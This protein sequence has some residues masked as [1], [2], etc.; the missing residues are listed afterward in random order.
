MGHGVHMWRMPDH[1]LC[2]R[3]PPWAET[4]PPFPGPPTCPSAPRGDACRDSRPLCLP[5]LSSFPCRAAS[6]EVP[7]CSPSL[8]TLFFLQQRSGLPRCP[9]PYRQ[10]LFSLVSAFSQTSRP[11]LCRHLGNNEWTQSLQRVTWSAT[12]DALLH[13]GGHSAAR[14]TA[15]GSVR[16]WQPGSSGWG[17]RQGRAVRGVCLCVK[18][19][20]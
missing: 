13:P 16:P 15:P 10:G 18:C 7:P 4:Q 5:H 1:S 12:R 17:G 19:V 2:P 20:Y 8:P 6:C 9:A 11:E 14:S 3:Q